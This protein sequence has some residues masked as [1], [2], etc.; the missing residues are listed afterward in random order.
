MSQH[1]AESPRDC[2]ATAAR[3]IAFERL[4]NDFFAQSRGQGWRQDHIHITEH[5]FCPAQLWTE[6]CAYSG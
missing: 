5:S 3:A 1:T 6:T 4:N 2:K